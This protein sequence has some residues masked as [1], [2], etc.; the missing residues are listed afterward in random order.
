MAEFK[1]NDRVRLQAR[2]AEWWKAPKMRKA[3]ET[4]RGA[5]IIAVWG[6]ALREQ[7]RT[8]LI[9]F[10]VLRKNAPDFVETVKFDY[11]ELLPKKSV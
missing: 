7:D 6:T 10:D 3:A 2:T 5:T 8:F 4:G 9:R 1:E 11:I